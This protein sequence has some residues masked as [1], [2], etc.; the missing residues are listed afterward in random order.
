[1]FVQGFPKPVSTFGKPCIAFEK[2]IRQNMTGAADNEYTLRQGPAS[3]KVPFGDVGSH[4]IHDAHP[5]RMLARRQDRR[6]AVTSI[7]I[8]M[9]GSD[10]PATII[11]AAGRMSPKAR[12]RTGQHGSKSSRLGR[13]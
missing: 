6:R 13:M 5:K 4:A 9:R 12:R 10:R 7:S 3:L 2:G 8:F 1:M 11:V